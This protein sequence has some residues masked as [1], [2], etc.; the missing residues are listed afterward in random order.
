MCRVVCKII[1]CREKRV[2]LLSSV[3][4]GV[5]GFLLVF[6]FCLLFWCGGGVCVGF[7]VCIL[8]GWISLFLIC[9]G[10]GWVVV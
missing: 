2:V 9:F 1:V 5:N 3:S 8:G 4:I 10:G 6:W 7:W